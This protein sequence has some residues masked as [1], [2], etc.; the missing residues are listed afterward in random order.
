MKIFFQNMLNEVLKV[1]KNGLFQKNP[2]QGGQGHGISS[3]IE[4]RACESSRGQLKKKQNFQGCLRKNCGISM[5]L[6]F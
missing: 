5:G 6:G 4:E 2:K 3:G 1:V